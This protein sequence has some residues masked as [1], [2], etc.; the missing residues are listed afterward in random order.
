MEASIAA[1]TTGD[2]PTAM[3]PTVEEIHVDPT[4]NT[5][6]ADPTL[7]TP[8]LLRAMMKCIWELI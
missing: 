6:I 7:T 3:D 8:P 2:L 4:T 1:P 5:E